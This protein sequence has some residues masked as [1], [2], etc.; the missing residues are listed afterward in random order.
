MVS[1]DMDGKMCVGTST[2]GLFMKKK[3]RVGD[4]PIPGSG[5][6]VDDNIGG[7]VAT[8]LGEDI[9]K[10]CISYEIV[11][12]MGEGHKPQEAAEKAV[13]KLNREL[14]KRRGKAGDISVVCM[15]NKGEWGGI[16]TNIDKF[17]F[18]VATA[19]LNPTVYLA[20]NEGG[21][22]RMELVKE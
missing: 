18:A 9:M 4:S 14:I 8:G 2:S 16:A 20:R 21:K 13:E 15:N 6:Y 3:G 17:T 11:R 7:A 5:F 22:T 12:L 10:G 1:L 19:D